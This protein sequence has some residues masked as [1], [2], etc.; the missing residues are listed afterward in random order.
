[1]NKEKGEVR[2]EVAGESYLLCYTHN[3]IAELEEELNTEMGEI[4]QSLQDGKWSIRQSRAIIKAGFTG[5]AEKDKGQRIS[6]IQAGQ[7]LDKLK[8]ENEGME[9][10]GE[11]YEAIMHVISPDQAMAGGG[12]EGENPTLPKGNGTTSE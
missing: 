7:I 10:L 3:A 2:M 1:M 8:K 11:C 12:E 6:K 4:A 9:Q 5:A